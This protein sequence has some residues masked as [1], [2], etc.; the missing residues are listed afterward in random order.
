MKKKS[1]SAK[2]S[3]LIGFVGDIRPHP[4]LFQTRRV[5]ILWICLSW[6]R[7]VNIILT[8][9]LKTGERCCYG[10]STIAQCAVFEQEN[11]RFQLD[12]T[13]Y[14]FVLVSCARRAVGGSIS[15]AGRQPLWERHFDLGA[16][17]QINNVC[18]IFSTSKT[19]VNL[20][21]IDWCSHRHSQVSNPRPKV[22]VKWVQNS[23]HSLVVHSAERWDIL[24]TAIW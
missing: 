9:A 11:R 1:K 12:P 16:T 14:S 24:D 23:A 17:H 6:H 20:N 7:N 22:V 15:E 19:E 8:F 5:S 3:N 2:S 10:S 21:I 18:S 4:S 13:P